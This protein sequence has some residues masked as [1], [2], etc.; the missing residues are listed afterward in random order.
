MRS[1]GIEGGHNVEE[2]HRWERCNGGGRQNRFSPVW[3][4]DGFASKGRRYAFMRSIDWEGRLGGE[5]CHLCTHP[6]THTEH[7]QRGGRGSTRTLPPRGKWLD[8]RSLSRAVFRPAPH[9]VLRR[10]GIASA[11]NSQPRNV[12]DE[13]NGRG[14][15]WGQKR[16]RGYL[17][18]ELLRG[19]T[20][21]TTGLVPPPP[22]WE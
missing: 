17:G 3:G 14:P 20:L 9:P 5:R 13:R 2:V 16:A 1:G 6:C 18:S 7:T 22:Q 19:T 4:F 11:S 8:R 12:C 15:Q 10:R 21:G